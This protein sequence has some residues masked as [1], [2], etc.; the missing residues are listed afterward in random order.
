MIEWVTPRTMTIIALVMGTASACLLAWTS[1]FMPLSI[2]KSGEVVFGMERDESPDVFQ[3]R[4]RR[5]RMIAKVLNPVAFALL[6]ASFAL[7]SIALFAPPVEN[8]KV[9]RADRYVT[10]SAA[11][12]DRLE[13]VERSGQELLQQWVCVDQTEWPD[14]VNQ[15]LAYW[16]ESDC[17][18]RTGKPRHEPGKD[19]P[20]TSLAPP[21]YTCFSDGKCV[22][23]K[24]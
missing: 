6:A 11:R 19:V 14:A 22:H 2:L 15:A 13:S 4:N 18:R 1:Q 10:I 5:R 21:P 16:R 24:P 8:S 20:S 7:Q 23:N 12:L 9:E 17:L 3:A